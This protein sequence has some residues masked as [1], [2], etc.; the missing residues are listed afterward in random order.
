MEETPSPSNST[1]SSPS[2][3]PLVQVN[4]ET[5]LQTGVDATSPP[6][7]PRTSFDS[8]RASLEVRG[9]LDIKRATG[10][11]VRGKKTGSLK[12][13]QFSHEKVQV[14]LKSVLELDQLQSPVYDVH[15]FKQW[16]RS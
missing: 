10:G 16:V 5:F 6:E 2:A 15:P 14:E 12:R 9:S 8:R 7:S 3:I 11:S 4:G 1:P 13:G